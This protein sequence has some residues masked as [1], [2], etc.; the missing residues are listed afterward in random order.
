MSMLRKKIGDFYLVKHIG[1]GG[2]SEVFLGLN[3][4]TR[5]KRAFKILG[6]SAT[7]WPGAYARFL[8]EVDI[9]RSLSHPGIIQIFDNGVLDDC[10]FYSMEYMPGGNLTRLLQRGKPSFEST[11]QVFFQIC[12]AMAYAHGNGIIHRDLKPA[13]IL[14]RTDGKPV[15]SDFGIAKIL[16]GEHPPLTVS[17]EILGTIAYLAPEQRFNTKRVN[18]RADIYALGALFYEML[19]GFPPLGKFPRPRE[20][21]PDFPE[22]L[23][24]ILEKC[25]AIKPEDRFENAGLLEIELEKCLNIVP[26]KKREAGGEATAKMLLSLEQN[27]SIS[28]KSDR[29]ESWFRVLRTGTTRE[30]LAVVREMVDKLAPGEAKAILKLYPQEGDRV[31][32]GLI[33]VLGELKIQAA[34]PLILTDLKSPFHT[35]CAIEA[36]G[37]IGL[38]ESY[39]ALLAYVIEHPESALIA[40]IP[41]ANTGKK[42]AVKFLRQFLSNEMSVLRQTAVRALASVGSEECLQALKDRLCI[43]CDEKVRLSI[44]QAVHSLESSLLS[45][46]DAT[47]IPK[48]QDMRREYPP[49]NKPTSHSF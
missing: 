4:R 40:M 30:R 8:R 24:S 46:F 22:D 27:P 6:K 49:V 41:L 9:I 5:E 44:T 33:K 15:V 36:L 11:E 48:V 26:R 38:A 32:W 43:E 31:R 21:N 13:N 3:P 2:M 47:T 23:Q 29:I 19:M 12:E 35:E 7:L 16:D 17:G 20:I 10:Y 28:E 37:K 25:L 34:T 45:D 39:N 42:R 1:A 18:Q 14:L